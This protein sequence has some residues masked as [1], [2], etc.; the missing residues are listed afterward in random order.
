MYCVKH[1]DERSLPPAW[2]FSRLTPSNA[3]CKRWMWF[4]R[5][6]LFCFKKRLQRTAELIRALI[7]QRKPRFELSTQIKCWRQ[8]HS[9]SNSIIMCGSFPL[10]DLWSS[11]CY[12]IA[13]TNIKQAN[14]NYRCER[15]FRQICTFLCLPPQSRSFQICQTLA[16]KLLDHP[17]LTCL[18]LK[19]T[20]ALIRL[21]FL[22]LNGAWWVNWITIG[23]QVDVMWVFLWTDA[24]KI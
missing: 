22:H 2:I 3:F 20:I 18:L 1:I 17:T 7:P 9:Y 19:S 11:Y 10:A 21:Q 5:L 12:N 23:Y 16:H 13:M 24:V 14:A 4:S 8:G 15:L 6:I